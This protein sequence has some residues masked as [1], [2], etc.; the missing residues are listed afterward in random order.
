MNRKK[1]S[2]RLCIFLL[3]LVFTTLIAVAPANAALKDDLANVLSPIEDV[4]GGF[5]ARVSDEPATWM[6]VFVLIGL[7]AVLY[8][9]A[10]KLK[11]PRNIAGVIAMVFALIGAVGIPGSALE[12]LMNMYG[13]IAVAIM[14]LGPAIALAYLSWKAHDE[15]QSNYVYIVLAMVWGI[16]LGIVMAFSESMQK[17]GKTLAG[18]T[19]SISLSVFVAVL[20]IIICIILFFTKGTIAEKLLEK[21]ESRED[22]KRRKSSLK[23]KKELTKLEEKL[24]KVFEIDVIEI[25][26]WLKDNLE[27]KFANKKLLSKKIEEGRKELVALERKVWRVGNMIA[28]KFPD[29]KDHI[30]K[31]VGEEE[32]I[33]ARTKWMVGTL[34]QL[35]EAV[36]SDHL[37]NAR[38]RLNELK[39]E[40]RNILIMLSSLEREFYKT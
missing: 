36:T 17:F 2:A 11:F 29:K 6:K 14:I 26:N 9:A 20:A 5:F 13:G 16:Y 23:R 19:T 8:F 15:I 34:E 25:V 33:L 21:G 7:F 40:E 27:S 31:I 35:K 39:R 1:T 28:D 3:L 18:S 37:G 10:L 12:Y 30:K 32:G 22:Y 4:V 38:A 24:I